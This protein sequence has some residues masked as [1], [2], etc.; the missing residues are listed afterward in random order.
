MILLEVNG[1]PITFEIDTGSSHTIISM[2]DWHRL[3]S[4]PLSS[5]KLRLKCYSGNCLAITG[6]C[7]VPVEYHNHIYNLKLI[8]VKDAHLPLLGLQWIRLL[9]LD[10]NNLIRDDQPDNHHIHHVVNGSKLQTILQKYKHV[11][12][13][14]SGHCTKMKA[15]IE[16]KPNTSPKFFKPHP[17]PF[18]YLDRVKE[19]IAQK[20]AAGIVERVDTS[21][22]A[23]PIV[24]VQK[25]N[26][27]IR[28][29]GDFK[30]TINPHTLIDQH[31][32]PSIDELF[33]RLRNGQQFT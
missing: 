7:F 17:I 16:L 27:K 4:P 2:L 8:V 15:H 29:C 32:I 24:P 13:S 26:G 3:Q 18:A 23:A 25:P 1:N 21:L 6:E 28:I 19:E 5:S 9:Q 22:W 33:S 11:L 30:V 10:L 14:K 12:N 20:V 31:P